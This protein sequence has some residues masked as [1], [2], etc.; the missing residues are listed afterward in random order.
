M[1]MPVAMRV[2]SAVVTQVSLHNCMH[3]H[4]LMPV[5]MRVASAVVTRAS[6]HDTSIALQIGSV[7]TGSYGQ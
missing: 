5:G 1:L 4:M 6:Y 3:V 7:C 2:A